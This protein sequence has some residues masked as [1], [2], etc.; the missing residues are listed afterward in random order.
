MTV[1]NKK[2][3]A[4]RDARTIFHLKQQCRQHGT[5]HKT[6]QKVFIGLLRIHDNHLALFADE[7]QM[8]EG[9]NG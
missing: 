1:T 9:C 5:G 4:R 8:Q 7:I 2:Q 6:L 3:Q